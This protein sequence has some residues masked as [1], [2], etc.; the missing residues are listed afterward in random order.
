[1]KTDKD[2][3]LPAP[4]ALKPGQAVELEILA[5]TD[6]G[7]KALVDERYIGLL[8]HSEISQ[9]LETG[10]RL[11]GWVKGL[12]AKGKIDL[13]I[14]RLDDE[15]RNALESTILDYLNSCGG[16][17]PLSDKSSP[18]EIHA[19]FAAS[20][21]NFKRAIGRLY[22]N[23]Q[24]VIAKHEIRLPEN[25]PAETALQ[26]QQPEEDPVKKPAK[27]KQT[28]IWPSAKTDRPSSPWIR[29]T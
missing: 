6:L 4:N 9:P 10:Q 19:L 1:M 26:E 8:Y 17:A 16:S 12:R 11:R 13:T 20:K 23:R 7:Y 27:Q 25:I 22:K 14:T 15:G 3:E 21:S 18:E 2:Y 29:K 5:A 24:I 28:S